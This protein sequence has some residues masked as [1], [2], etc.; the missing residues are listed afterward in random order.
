M[1]STDLA[2]IQFND[3]PYRYLSDEAKGYSC[4]KLPVN[5]ETMYF[6]DALRDQF[7]KQ[8][9]A[10][11][12]QGSNINYDAPFHMRSN[13]FYVRNERKDRRSILLNVRVTD[14]DAHLPFPFEVGEYQANCSYS[15]ENR[16]NMIDLN[17]FFGSGPDWFS[18]FDLVISAIGHFAKQRGCI[19]CFGLADVN[20]PRVESLYRKYG[21]FRP[22][23][24]FPAPISYQDFS[25]CD[26]Q[27][28]KPVEVYWKILEWDQND[29]DK[30]AAKAS[31]YKFEA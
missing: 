28:S 20:K 7:I 16:E 26:N 11:G 6:A 2:N 25:F 13:Y 8:T 5:N 29:I 19:R 27:D 24:E 3:A 15:L 21:G 1:I 30:Y 31:V 14:G 10:M 12:Y 23:L 4:Y 17:T 22:S 18:G 9:Q